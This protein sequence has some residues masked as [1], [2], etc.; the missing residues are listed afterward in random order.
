M[1]DFA[2]A[3]EPERDRF[4]VYES[5]ETAYLSYHEL[6]DGSL[7]FA[8][9]YTPLA[10]RGRGIATAIIKTALEYARHQG[11]QI[12]PTCPFVA[13]YIDRHREYQAIS[14]HH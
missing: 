4:A 7:D 14:R 9:T 11:K 2:V 10:I 5:G 12:E 13:T 3:H 8:Y 1:D 6:E